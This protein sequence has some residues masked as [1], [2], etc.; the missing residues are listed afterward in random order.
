MTEELKTIELWVFH[1]QEPTIA[2]RKL[3][4]PAALQR[5]RVE[6]WVA[7]SHSVVNVTAPDRMADKL[8][9]GLARSLA[10]NNVQEVLQQLH[11]LLA[12]NL[13][14]HLV[15]EVVGSSR[16]MRALLEVY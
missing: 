14:S 3:P 7:P 6:A 13:D 1:G 9:D 16:N 2:K 15:L 12:E 11:L 10:Q 4:A 8:A 5:I